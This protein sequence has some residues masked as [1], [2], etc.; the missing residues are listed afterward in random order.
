MCEIC[1]NTKWLSIPISLELHHI[2]GN[3]NNNDLL[4][5]QLLC[6]N[7]HSTT[8]NYRGKNKKKVEKQNISDET[9]IQIIPDSYT[10]R[11]A[12]LKV[13]LKAAG[14]NYARIKKLIITNNLQF[15]K[16]PKSEKNIKRIKTIEEKYGSFKELFNNKIQWP[17]KEELE[18]MIATQSM[19]SIG[20][21]LGVSDNSVRKTA[22]KYGI[23]VKSISK[24]SH[25]HG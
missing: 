20:K 4:N 24:W 7:C 2:D 5:L 14:A 6:P 11:H 8:P 15:K 10:I 12:L 17:P 1:Y 25:K 13:G 22:K 16:T 18:K 19:R 21:K 23:D 9:L 3:P